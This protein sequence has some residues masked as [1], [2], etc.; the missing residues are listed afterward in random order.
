M[1][2]K[3]HAGRLEERLAYSRCG[4]DDSRTVVSFERDRSNE[5]SGRLF[6]IKRAAYGRWA[7]PA[8]SFRFRDLVARSPVGA[9][10][11]RKGYQRHRTAGEHHHAGEARDAAEDAGHHDRL[12]AQRAEWTA[13]A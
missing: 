8:R 11:D 4:P 9:V 12:R 7:G 2:G 13:H 6:V 5:P 10:P 3:T 1:K